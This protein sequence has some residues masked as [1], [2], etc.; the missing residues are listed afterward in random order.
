MYKCRIAFS[1]AVAALMIAA[2]VCS[3]LAQSKDE[4]K[5]EIPEVILKAFQS[6]YPDAKITG[7]EQETDDS[8]T[9]FEIECTDGDIEKD[10]IL[11]AEGKIIQVEQEIE[12]SSLPE[13]VTKAALS[14][15][16]GAEIEEAEMIS[17]DSIVEYEIVIEVGEKE[18]EA[19]VT[20]DGT[21]V[22]S[23]EIVDDDEGD[24]E[25]DEDSDDEEHHE[26]EEDDD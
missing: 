5:P 9:V 18:I 4:A 23:E 1:V 2:F 12:V 13:S 26:D 7:F 15:F 14:A 11:S 17:R 19:L 25:D 6:E 22:E 21:I 20:A 24:H 10:V 8:L 16:Q 3:G